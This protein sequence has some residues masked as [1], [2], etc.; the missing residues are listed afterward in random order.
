MQQFGRQEVVAAFLVV[1]LVAVG[2]ILAI[3]CANVAGLLLSRLASRGREMALRVALGASKRR[4]AQQ[5]LA[6]GFWLAILGTAGGLLLMKVTMACSRARRC[7]CP[8]R[9]TFMP[10]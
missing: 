8:L 10:T 2:S 9:S 6:E 5:L 1:L 7:R 3:T 4:L